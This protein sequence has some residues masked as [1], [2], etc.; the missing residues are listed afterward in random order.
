MVK[1][2]RQRRDP[3]TWGSS[4]HLCSCGVLS[5]HTQCHGR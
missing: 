1:I 2:S 4:A 5:A 3:F